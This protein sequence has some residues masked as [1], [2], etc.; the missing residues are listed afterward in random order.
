MALDDI[1]IVPGFYLLSIQD[2][3]ANCRAFATDSRWTPGWLPLFANGG[4]DFYVLDLSSPSGSPVRHFRIE[5][6]EHP[7]EFGSLRALLTTLAEAF[8]RGVFFVDP[9][10]YLEMDDVVFGELATELN[11]DVGWWRD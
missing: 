4:G 1:H 6:P 11:P 8:E 9:N 2:A 3:I 10:G 5:E 7:I